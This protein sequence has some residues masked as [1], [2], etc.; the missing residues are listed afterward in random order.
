[1][2]DVHPTSEF[3]AGPCA[4]RQSDR[5]A[6]YAAEAG[7]LIEAGL[8]YGCRCSRQDLAGAAD[9]GAE[10]RYPGTCASLGLPPGDGVTWRLRMAPGVETFD[11]LLLGAQRQDPAA[12][13]GDMAI[14]DRLGNWSYQ[15][16]AGVD[17]HL[18][19]I[20]LVVRGR[21]LL[22]STGRQIR[23]GRLLGRRLPARFA[24]HGLV[25]KSA[26]QKLSKS[27]GDT[28]V[29]DLRAAGWSRE[30]VIDDAARRVRAVTA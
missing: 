23:L 15:F 26:T 29:R 14:R 16:V 10:P 24:H 28:G 21:D 17:D 18:Q 27:D 30:A 4:S 5:R 2:P 1:M 7:R 25:M 12:Q 9:P 19:G 22:A 3:R 11:D 8:V 6:I 13:C 20:T